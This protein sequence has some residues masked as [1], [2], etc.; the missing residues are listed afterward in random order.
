MSRA[1]RQPISLFQNPCIENVLAVIFNISFYHFSG[2]C[3]LTSRNRITA[4]VK[5]FTE[6]GAT[7][8][9]SGLFPIE[10]I[11]GLINK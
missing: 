7:V 1:A 4:M 9:S 11:E 2:F 3:L 8:G 6:G 10:G 5:H